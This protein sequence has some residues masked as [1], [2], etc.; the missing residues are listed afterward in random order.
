[1][2]RPTSPPPSPPPRSPSP[3][4][5]P[6]RPKRPGLPSPRKSGSPPAPPSRW[7]P[8]GPGGLFCT[9]PPPTQGPPPPKNP[10][11]QPVSPTTRP[12][13]D[14]RPRSPRTGPHNPCWPRT[15]RHPVR[16]GP[17]AIR[18]RPEVERPNQFPVIL[19][20]K[21]Q[22]RR[23]RAHNII[24]VPGQTGLGIAPVNLQTQSLGTLLEHRST[25]GCIFGRLRFGRQQP[26][27][28][29]P[30][31]RQVPLQ[32][33]ERLLAVAHTARV[34]GPGRDDNRDHYVS[35][36]LRTQTVAARRPRC[37]ADWP[38]P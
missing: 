32:T 8:P 30:R 19:H 17:R 11:P 26:A 31:G 37:A 3:S 10:R 21:P 23:E 9:Q 16:R 14:Q 20:I 7:L 6:P 4:P 13:P 24:Q 25:P 34:I 5:P 33:A 36:Y 28:L 35:P 27:Q 12:P 38:G 2:W 18:R 1:M 15:A 29:M 22:R